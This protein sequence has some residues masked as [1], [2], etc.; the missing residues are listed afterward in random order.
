MLQRRTQTA[1][2]WVD[3]LQIEPSDIE[4]LYSV[5][6]EHETPLTIDEMALYLVR[7]RVQREEEELARAARPHEV[8]QPCNT[9]EIGQE[10]AFPQFGYAVGKVIATRPGE[11]KDDGPFTVIQVELRDGRIVDLAS[12][13]STDHVLNH[14]VQTEAELEQPAL[15]PEELFI[16]YG[17]SVTDALEMQLNQHDDL[18]RVAGRWFPRSL[19]AEVNIGHL[20]LAEA[21][22]DIHGGGPMTTSDLLAQIG[23]MQGINPRLAEFSMNYGMQEDPRFDEVGPAGQVLWYLT[24]MEPPEVRTPP[25]RLAYEPIEYDPQVL[26]PELRALELEIEDEHSKIPVQRSARPQSVRVVMTYAHRRSGTLPLSHQ[27]RRMFPTAYESPRIR[28]TVIDLE[29]GDTIPAWVVRPGGYVYGLADWF[30]KH[31]V[32]VGG[33]LTV[34]RTDTPG[35]VG[36]SYARRSPRKEWLRTALVEGNRLRFENQQRVIGCDYDELTAI[37]VVDDLAVDMLWKRV[38]ERRIPLAN[39]MLD[40]SRE[41]AALNPQGY[42]H[43]KTLYSAI[44]IVR[45]CPPGPIFSNLVRM[46][47]FEDLGSL[48]WRLKDTHTNT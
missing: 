13:L 11:N 35:I 24:R 6:L 27:L 41:L 5:L 21:V 37:N 47:E 33:Y 25:P 44:N 34:E 31:D 10:M 18:V 19:L 17:G 15:T 38:L 28:F 8:Y 7:Y 26:T 12:N 45:R 40:I 48:Y 3:E 46:P 42:F 16:E 29:T 20:N 14:V 39:L 22:L 1:E 4:Y 32:P 30:E 2:Y 23:M 9:Y 43:A 36:I